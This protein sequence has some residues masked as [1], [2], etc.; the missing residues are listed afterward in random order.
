MTKEIENDIRTIAEDTIENLWLGTMSSGVVRLSNITENDYQ[1]TYFD[2]SQGLPSGGVNVQQLSEKKILFATEKGI[3]TY[4]VHQNKFMPDTTYGAQFADGSR[5]VHRISVDYMQNIWLNTYL[6]KF[7]EI[8]F[9]KLKP[10]KE[11]YQWDL[12]KFLKMPQEI[13]QAFYHDKDSVTWLGGTIGVIRYDPKIEYK[14]KL[15]YAP[16][17]RKVSIGQDSVIFWGTYCQM[18]DTDNYLTSIISSTQPE[19]LKPILPYKYNSLIIEFTVPAFEDESANEFQYFLQGFD[20]QWSNWKKKYLAEYTNLPPG[21]YYFRL[22][23]RNVYKSESKET[24]YEFTIT[25][26]FYNTIWFYAGQILFILMLFVVAFYYGR[27][28]R[29]IR[30]ARILATVAIFIVFEYLQTFAE[31]NLGAKLGSIIFIKVLLNVLLAFILLPVE[32]YLKYFITAEIERKKIKKRGKS[33]KKTKKKKAKKEPV[34]L[35]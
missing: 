7:F 5:G 30:I 19:L 20:K 15:D 21:H 14:Y 29:S 32:K 16:I 23:A 6:E 33:I 31:E 18:N 27:T 3:F 2:T 4:L 9:A 35:K 8:G 17:I 24:T 22:K 1:V 13:Y 11:V 34:Q 12:N 26:P 25:P 28:G 10:G